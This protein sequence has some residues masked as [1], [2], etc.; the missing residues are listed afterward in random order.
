MM[1][2]YIGIYDNFSEEPNC[3]KPVSSIDKYYFSKTIIILMCLEGS[4]RFNVHFKDYI[5]SKNT[6]LVIGAGTP[7]FYT[8]KSSSLRVRIVAV[9]NSIFDKVAQGLIRIYFHRLMIQR[10]LHSISQSKMDMCS[11]IHSYLKG[12]ITEEDN[13]FKMQI[14]KNYLNILFYEACNIFLN[15]Q[16]KKQS[17]KKKYLTDRFLADVESN[18]KAERKIPFYARRLGIT[19]KYL[20]TLV[21]KETGRSASGWIEEYTLLEAMKLLREGKM[22]IYQV[23]YELSFSTPSHFGTFFRKHTGKTP[24]QFIRANKIISRNEASLPE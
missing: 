7:F 13:Y 10:P 22:T 18:F 19:P 24:K 14:I 15:E 1:D 16:E 21:S 11:S 6:F 5:L 2:D 20:S 3:N 4:A 9:S 8:E 17:S 23:A 12:F